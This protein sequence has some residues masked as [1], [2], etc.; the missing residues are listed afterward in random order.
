[1][2]F[3]I[4]LVLIAATIF[5]IVLPLWNLSGSGENVLPDEEGFVEL[6]KLVIGL[7]V[8][9]PGWFFYRLTNR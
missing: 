6:G 3:F 1:M 5:F 8:V 2:R 9:C 4:K 7:V